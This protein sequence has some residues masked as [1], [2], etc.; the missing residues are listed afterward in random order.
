M[1]EHPDYFNQ[2]APYDR[3]TVYPK[4]INWYMAEIEKEKD[5]NLVY[6]LAETDFSDDEVLLNEYIE[7]FEG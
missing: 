2:P 7:I 6:H 4:V 5:I 1:N 3:K